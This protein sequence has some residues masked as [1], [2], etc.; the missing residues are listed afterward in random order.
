[1]SGSPT[2]FPSQFFLLNPPLTS[3]DSADSSSDEQT[4]PKPWVPLRPSCSQPPTDTARLRGEHGETP[5]LQAAPVMTTVRLCLEI[6][7]VPPCP[8]FA[9]EHRL[10]PGTAPCQ[11]MALIHPVIQA[12]I[13][14]IDPDPS[15]TPSPSPSLGIRC[16]LAPP[17]PPWSMPRS[18]PGRSSLPSAASPSNA[19][20]LRSAWKRGLLGES[21]RVLPLLK[22]PPWL[23]C[24][25]RI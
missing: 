9:L 24:A 6:L 8:H 4:P 17:L 7:Q 13:L 22:T 21:D 3:G 25:L 18:P 19:R 15:T 11:R 10:L 16:L 20:S 5:P 14:R 2:R 23:P 1:M 12:G